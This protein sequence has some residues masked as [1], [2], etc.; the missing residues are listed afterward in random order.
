MEKM[1]TQMKM[2]L[3]KSMNQSHSVMK[4]DFWLCIGSIKVCSLINFPLF[5]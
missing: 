5:L 2:A 4:K 1:S 3:L